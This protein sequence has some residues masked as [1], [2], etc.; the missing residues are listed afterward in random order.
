MSEN[1]I[2]K[3][4]NTQPYGPGSA[5]IWVDATSN[6][7]KFNPDG[8]VRVIPSGVGGTLAAAGATAALLSGAGT[9]SSPVTTS[10][11]GKNFLGYWVDST[12]TSGDT[13]GIY[14]RLYI[15]GAGQ[16]GE[17]A[18]FY[19]TVN[20][21][22]AATGG[23]V[24]GAHISLNVTGASGKISGSANALRA[25]LDFA[26]TPTTVGGLCS[27]A[28][29]DSNIA[30]GPTIP[31]GTAFLRVA[32]V[33]TQK[34]SYLLNIPTTGSGLLM[35]PHTTQV[36]TDSIRIVMADGNVRYIMCTTASSN[37]TGGA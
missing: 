7:L 30:A 17:A 36:M 31:A 26:A 27:V 23:T 13:R 3:T 19:T 1:R 12:A 18:R 8:T 34:L 5:G 2:R 35:A 20:N 9:S 15:S 32:D 6:D 14:T 11:A 24:N 21:V 25:T 29:L 37:R 16:S 10:A 4:S 28:T 22:T 33:G